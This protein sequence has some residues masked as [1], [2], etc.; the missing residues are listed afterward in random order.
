MK[1]QMNEPHMEYVET[2]QYFTGNILPARYFTGFFISSAGK[3]ENV[4]GSKIKLFE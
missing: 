3:T 4:Q 1:K 2:S